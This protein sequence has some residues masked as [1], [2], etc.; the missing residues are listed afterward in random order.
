[1][2]KYRLSV[3]LFL[4]GWKQESWS[5][6]APRHFGFKEISHF[7]KEFIVGISAMHVYSFNI[8]PDPIEV[9]NEILMVGIRMP[10]RRTL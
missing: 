8:R 9:L 2:T 1:M 6:D 7:F 3:N 4:E 10:S 5:R